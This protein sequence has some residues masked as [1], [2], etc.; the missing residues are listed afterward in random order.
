MLVKNLASIVLKYKIQVIL[1]TNKKEYVTQSYNLEQ[2]YVIMYQ[3]S[4]FAVAEHNLGQCHEN[5]VK[6]PKLIKNS[7]FISHDCL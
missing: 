5:I 3:L 7:I 4:A 1:K 2:L 6:L